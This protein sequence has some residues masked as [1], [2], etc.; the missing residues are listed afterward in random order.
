MSDG[1]KRNSALRGCAKC[2][3]ECCRWWFGGWLAFVSVLRLWLVRPFP[4]HHCFCLTVVTRVRWVLESVRQFSD[5]SILTSSISGF[6]IHPN[7]SFLDG[8]ATVRQLDAPASA[9]WGV[10]RHFC[11]AWRWI[12]ATLLWRGLLFSSH[13]LNTSTVLLTFSI[14]MNKLARL[15]N[16]TPSQEGSHAVSATSEISYDAYASLPAWNC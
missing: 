7:C 1:G 8:S 16:P 14:R 3:C 9:P 5:L 13:E 12:Y 2:C 4:V 11:G 10:S 6:C 15:L